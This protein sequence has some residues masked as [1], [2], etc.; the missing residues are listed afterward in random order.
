MVTAR[1]IDAPACILA[2]LVASAMGALF[3]NMLPLY[4]G[5]AQDFKQL[6][7]RETGLISGAFFL[8]YNVATI[9]AFFWIRRWN[10]RRVCIIAAPLAAVAL[11]AGVGTDNYPLLLTVTAVAGAALAAI[12]GIG[13]TAIG[14]TANASRWYG[15]KIAGEAAVGAIL[16]IVL[17]GT[18]VA[19]RGF[20]GLVLGM[21]IAMAVL[22]PL[23]WYMPAE[24]SKAE[25]GD[26]DIPDVGDEEKPKGTHGIWI[27]LAGLLVF[28]AGQ[29][30]VWAFVE[31]LGSAGGF[32]PQTVGNLLSVTLFCAVGGSITTAAL[33]DR[34]GNVWPFVTACI[35]YF[36]SLAL[37][38][39]GSAFV[40]YAAGACVVTYS[41]GMGLPFAVARIAELD[42]DG[43]YVVL[44]VP[45]IGIG[46]MIG[47]PIAG[48]LTTGDSL[49]PILGFGGGAVLA[50]LLLV[51]FARK[52]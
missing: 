40:F 42:E 39:Q 32:P 19:T 8:G 10:W 37:L 44:S 48:L 50:A 17:P 25:R 18:L 31:R 41:F 45:A 22:A 51:T 5:L 4:L 30:T 9:S 28:F 13:T 49:A 14:D 47:P 26:L 43:R 38:S 3:Y 20:E 29:T 52:H 36:C 27:T 33:G 6:S 23:A 2:A 35:I 34:F 24:G 7:F 21:I 15:V 46:A 11:Y 12:Y 1:S 16:F